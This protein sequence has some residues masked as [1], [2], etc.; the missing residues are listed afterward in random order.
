[1]SN[2][3]MCGFE[4]GTIREAS[5]WEY[6]VGEDSIKTDKKRSGNY[7]CKVQIYD[8]VYFSIPAP[9]YTGLEEVYIQFAIL[10]DSLLG[11]NGYFFG[12]K[13]EQGNRRLGYLTV[14][15]NGQV[16]V[17]TGCSGTADAYDYPS[18]QDT[19]R[20][21]SHTRLLTDVWYVFELYIKTSHTAGV[22]TM[23]IDGN[24]EGTFS[25]DTANSDVGTLY[26]T[27]TLDFYNFN[28]IY[29]DDVIVDDAEWPG[30]QKVVL[31]RPNEDGE[32]IEWSKTNDYDN[33]EH[34]NEV[35]TDTADYVY[36]TQLNQTDIYKLER[37]P[38]E[39]YEIATVRG[40]AWSIKNSAS[41]SQ[42]ASIAFALKNGV[43][44]TSSVFVSDTQDLYLTW[45]LVSYSWDL[46]NPDTGY[47]WTVDDIN[48]IRAGVV[49]K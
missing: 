12:W 15:S 33:Y 48:I 14:G 41:A 24:L 35:P 32:V 42:N 26:G 30:C 1:M 6:S 31:L 39:A 10:F 28:G 9:G 43:T 5:G 11:M 7:S 19:L 3:V 2:L 27:D 22:I 38:D 21:A 40:D 18:A 16:L 20:L 25:G 36:T 29:F 37:L 45:T 46:V 47:T 49:S 13:G 8:H 34:V 4:W 44:T 23:K 17:Y